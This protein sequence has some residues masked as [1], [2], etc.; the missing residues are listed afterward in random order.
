MVGGLRRGRKNGG[1]GR[2]R[3]R[4][5]RVISCFASISLGKHVEWPVS[6]FVV[7]VVVSFASSSSCSIPPS[8]TISAVSIISASPPASV[9]ISISFLI[10]NPLSVS[11]IPTI[12]S[13]MVCSASSPPLLVIISPSSASPAKREKKTG[14][15]E[16]ENKYMDER[17]V[18]EGEKRRYRKSKRG[19]G[20]RMIKTRGI[21]GRSVW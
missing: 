3:V 7:F 18:R 17:R 20:A 2:R 14:E 4:E 15:K 19:K 16:K 12:T 6:K 9:P 1:E 21:L 8:S 13:V 5:R 10:S 11:V